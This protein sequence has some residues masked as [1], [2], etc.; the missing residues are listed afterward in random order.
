MSLR[1]H[2]GYWTWFS[3]NQPVASF[4]SFQAAWTALYPVC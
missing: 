4:P 2:K 1:F 3:G